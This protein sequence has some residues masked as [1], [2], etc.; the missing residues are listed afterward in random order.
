LEGVGIGPTNKM[1]G[2]KKMDIR[3]EYIEALEKVLCLGSCIVENEEEDNFTNEVDT[4]N[5]H[6][7]VALYILR[8]NEED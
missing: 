4:M 3:K 7:Q 6:T 2:D 8:K 5:M 1:K